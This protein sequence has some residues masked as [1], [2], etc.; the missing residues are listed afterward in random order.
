MPARTLPPPPHKPPPP[1]T[2]DALEGKRP[3][4]RPQQPLGRRLEEVAKAVGGGYCRLQMSV[5]V[6][7]GVRETLAWHR[8]GPLEGRFPSP[9][10]NAFLAGG[11]RWAGTGRRT[12]DP[13]RRSSR[14][15]RTRP[16]QPRHSSSPVTGKRTGAC[17]RV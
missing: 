17:A 15:A 14:T 8:L 1:P 5:Q 12:I 7:L 16:R 3:Q 6:A 13:Q 4:R 10:S 11:D 2:R 9:P